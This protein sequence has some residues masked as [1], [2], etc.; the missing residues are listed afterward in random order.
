MEQF[1]DQIGDDIDV[2]NHIKEVRN[3]NFTKPLVFQETDKFISMYGDIPTEE[4]EFLPTP[5][6]MERFQ[7]N[8]RASDF[9]NYFVYSNDDEVDQ[10]KTQD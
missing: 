2:L 7:V 1:F 4:E 3:E 6:W 9:L 8:R 5:L 10:I